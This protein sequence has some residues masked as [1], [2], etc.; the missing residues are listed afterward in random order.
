[1][2]PRRALVTSTLLLSWSTRGV[3][4]GQACSN[5]TAAHAPFF[6]EPRGAARFPATSRLVT[7]ALWVAPTPGRSARAVAEHAW[8]VRPAE[9]RDATAI[10]EV[11]NDYVA[12]T[13]I[14][15][16]TEPVPA[17]EMGERIAETTASNLPW[18]IVEEAARLGYAYASN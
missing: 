2:D 12:I 4:R 18:L 13:Y 15:F 10:V 1:M 16:K 5:Q 17:A 14:T 3:D 6:G 7:R 8:H 9:L 11:Y